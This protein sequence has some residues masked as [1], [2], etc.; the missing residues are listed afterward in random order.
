MEFI[1]TDCTAYTGAFW[2]KGALTLLRPLELTDA[3][4]IY[5]GINDQENS[6]YLLALGPFG[7]GFE[8]EWI[9]EKQ[10][11]SQS[12]ITVA[13]CLLDGTLIGTM[14]LHRIDLVNGTAETGAVIFSEAHRGKGYGSDA[15]MLLLDAA[16]NRLNLFKVQSRVIAYN[17]RSAA[18]SKKC[19]YVEEGRLRGQHHRFGERHDEILLAVFRDNWLPLWEQ[20]IKRVN[21]QV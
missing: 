16:F 19:G 7:L 3:P 10:K 8:E 21:D 1:M 6:K 13:V 15:K 18:Y 20:Y 5:R 2:R 17:M 4:I 9:R 12:D 14:G 11:P